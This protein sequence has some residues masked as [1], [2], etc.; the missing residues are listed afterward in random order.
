MGPVL[1]RPGLVQGN[2]PLVESVRIGPSLGLARLLYK[3]EITNPTGSYKDRFVAAEMRHILRSGAEAGLATSSGNTG[4]S[5]AAYCARSGVACA[6]VV[7]ERAPAG[8]LAQMQAHGARIFRVV[9]FI[10]SPVVT[11]NVMR[12]LADMAEAHV[13]PLVVPAYPYCPEGTAAGE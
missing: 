13:A 11:E 4:S 7:N 3:L 5:L 6:I 1:L 10:T 12:R 2:T 9:D 8:K